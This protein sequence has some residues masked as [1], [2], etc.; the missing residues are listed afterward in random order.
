[1]PQTEQTTWSL[2]MS[3]EHKTIFAL[4]GRTVV[5]IGELGLRKCFKCWQLATHPLLLKSKEKMLET[6]SDTKLNMFQ[7]ASGRV[8]F[9]IV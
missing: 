9:V 5:K 7:Y 8:S 3:Y 2:A 4:N 1:M 6:W